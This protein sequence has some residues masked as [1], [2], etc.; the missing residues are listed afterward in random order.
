MTLS[1][2]TQ[3]FAQV[4]PQITL[5]FVPKKSYGVG[6]VLDF[7]MTT[8]T[9]VPENLPD[10][11]ILD[12][13]QLGVLVQ[14]GIVSPL[15]ELFSPDFTSD[16]YPIALVAARLNGETYGL[17][18]LIS[19]EHLAYNPQEMNAPPLDWEGILGQGLV[20]AFP[21]QGEGGGV[22]DAFLFQYLA[23]GGSVVDSQGRPNLSQALLARTL[24]FFRE[25]GQGE[26]LAAGVL[27]TDAREAWEKLLAGEV[28]V[29][30]ITSREFLSA[31]GQGMG[32]VPLPTGL[33]PPAII[34]RVWA[35]VILTQDPV[36]REASM[37]L[38]R[39]MME[40]E[41]LGEWARSSGRIPTRP[42]ALAIAVDEG[43]YRDFL[44][45]QLVSA[46]VRPPISP[47]MAR[48]FQ[49]ALVAVLTAAA[50]P[51]EAASQAVEAITASQ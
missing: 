23:L 37:E 48:A 33:G 15:D 47:Q 21:L 8:S 51:Q 1:E 29:A 35:F 17:P 10:I 19:L 14:R 13:S 41:R 46:Y 9:V 12:A 32:F 34:A 50:E 16:L 27:D 44:T 11:A 6:G 2:V 18:A 31:P 24:Q 26:L 40:T 49:Q 25:M 42:S 43:P 36:R 20:W 45:S 3:A 39:L 38:I 7:I 4:H 30:E 28:D 5:E 22:A